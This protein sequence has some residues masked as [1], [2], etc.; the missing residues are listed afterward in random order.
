MTKS[1]GDKKPANGV[2][3]SQPSTSLQGRN[4]VGFGKPPAQTR[5]KKGVSGNP[6]GRPRGSRNIRS[7]I[8]EAFIAPVTIR[9]GDK[10][11][12]ISTLEALS[13][14]QLEQGIKGDHRSVLTVLKMAK[15]IGLLEAP[16]PPQYDLSKLT[17][18]ELDELER[19]TLETLPDHR[20]EN[21]T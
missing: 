1:R 10:T 17:D 9:Q 21:D 13:R 6:K 19:L 8:R 2:E 18:E 15:E 3:Q 20:E 11:R 16:K 7:S 14:K 12:R 5:F 4:G